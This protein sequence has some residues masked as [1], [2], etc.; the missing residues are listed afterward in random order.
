MTKQVCTSIFFL[1]GML[2]ARSQDIPMLDSLD[3]S[4]VPAGKISRFWIPVM[5]NALSQPVCVPVLVAKGAAP[6]P[7]LG[8]TAAIHGNELNGIPIIQTVFGRIDPSRLKG[9]LIAIPGMNVPSIDLS[10]R[11]FPD[12]EDLN[13]V[14]PGKPDG[15]SSEQYSYVAFQKII[16]QT[17]Y[18][19]DLHTASFG[20]VNAMYVRADL[21]KD[22][23]ARLARLCDADILLDGKSASTAN[24]AAGRTLRE[25]ADLHGIHTITIELGDPQVYQPEM[26]RRG[27]VS[28]MNI[29]SHLGM[30]DWPAE[31]PPPAAL[32]TRSYWIYTDEGGLLEVPVETAQRLRKGDLIGILR[33]PF[34]DVIKRYYAPE[35]GIVIG[36]SSNPAN[37]SGGRILHLGILK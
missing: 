1:F 10:Q 25:E 6:G 26:I 3:L 9:T 27:S 24:A 28:I 16:S 7:V 35:D 12:E 29:L 19:I 34:G 36:K 21:R 4:Q 2:A 32:C 15:T 17:D 33:N 5:R 11:L 13:R 31:T 23:L 14:F 37:R 22:T 18:L 8:L 20:R 30:S